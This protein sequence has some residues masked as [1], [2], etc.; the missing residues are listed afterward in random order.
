MILGVIVLAYDS[1]SHRFLFFFFL[2]L[3]F[4]LSFFFCHEI[5]VFYNVIRDHI[6]YVF[7]LL[8]RFPC[9]MICMS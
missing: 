7:S 4:F 3:S 8:F 6:V 2:F 1:W 9:V 5:H